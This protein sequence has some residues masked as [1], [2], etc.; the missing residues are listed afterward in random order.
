[1]GGGF[2]MSS[3]K[4]A[5]LNKHSYL[6]GSKITEE[7]SI[8]LQ[9]Y[10]PDMK[11]IDIIMNAYQ[12]AQEIFDARS[13]NS[14]A[15][16]T[17]SLYMDHVNEVLDA[18]TKDLDNFNAVIKLFN[19]F[20]KIQSNINKGSDALKTRLTSELICNKKYYALFSLDYYLEQSRTEGL[21]HTLS[22]LEE[23]VNTRA[24]TYYNIAYKEYVDILPGFENLIE[25]L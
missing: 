6:L 5:Y 12:K 11:R 17:L 14:I 24:N 23:D 19:S 13:I 18:Y 21:E 4:K 2:A 1:M 16:K 15:N 10:P 7:Y 22:E 8:S 20:Y 9:N 25:M 3:K